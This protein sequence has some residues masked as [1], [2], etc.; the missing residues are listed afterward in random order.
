VSEVEVTDA[1]GNRVGYDNRYPAGPEGYG[2]YGALWPDEAAVKLTLT[3]K[4][5]SGFLPSELIT[6]TNLQV[7]HLL[8]DR[9]APPNGTSL[10]N[11][12]GGIPIAVR[13]MLTDSW[14]AM[15]APPGGKWPFYGP[16]SYCVE[17]ELPTH[18]PGVIADIVEVANEV[19]NVLTAPDSVGPNARTYI[20][21]I[22]VD[23]TSRGKYHRRHVSG[24]I[25]ECHRR[26]TKDPHCGISG[27]TAM[28][29][30]RR[31]T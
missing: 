4:R 3:L 18:P 8:G 11:S 25:S 27:E 17:V 7:L 16:G 2:I 30:D 24:E 14:H 19:G 29:T 13:N 5:T 20:E 10:T 31:R 26:S 15:H 22:H 28:K 23:P 6:F 1:T 12:L 21:F 9:Y